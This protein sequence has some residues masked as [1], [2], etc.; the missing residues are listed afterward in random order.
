M[1]TTAAEPVTIRRDV[2]GLHPDG[3]F[4][5]VDGRTCSTLL[6]PGDVD[7]GPPRGVPLGPVEDAVRALGC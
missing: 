7:D 3:M 2:N 1:A 4:S 5:R 6:L